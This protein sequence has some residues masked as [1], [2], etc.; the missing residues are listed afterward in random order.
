MREALSLLLTPITQAMKPVFLALAVQED[1]PITFGVSPRLVL[2]SAER[3]E[4]TDGLCVDADIAKV[5]ELFGT[6]KIP[7][8]VTVTKRKFAEATTLEMDIKKALPKASDLSA[9][10]LVYL[11]ATEI[12]RVVDRQPSRLL[13]KEEWKFFFIGDLEVTVGWFSDSR[14]WHVSV[15]K[16]SAVRIWGAGSAVVSLN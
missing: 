10:Q 9:V 14:E 5:F 13:S 8:Q 12:Q 2:K 7:K 15:R 4:T 11:L 3:T 16:W 6:E 1:F